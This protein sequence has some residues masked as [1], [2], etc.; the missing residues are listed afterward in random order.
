[1][2]RPMR[3]KTLELIYFN[4]G[5]G[6][7]A[8]ATAIETIAVQQGRPW[9]VRCVNLLEVLDPQGR[10]EKLTCMAP[11]ALY[12]KRLAK[13]W[14]FGLAQELKLLQGMIRLGH[15][16]MV[17]K[18][19][20]HWLRGEPDMVVSLVPNF[21]RAMQVSLAAALPGVP[22]VT[23]LT[24]MADHPPNFWIEP[25][26]PQH[27]VCGTARAMAQ[28]REQGCAESHLHRTSGMILRP[29]FYEP[30]MLDRRL[31]QVQLGLDPDRPTG[32]VMFGGHGSMAM[33]SI[34][35][36]LSDVQLILMCGHNAPL[37]SKLRAMK[38]AAT[39]VA[40]G[41]TPEVKRYMQLA[42]FFIGKPGPASLSE[43]V[44][45]GLPVVT[46]RNAWTMPQERYNTEWV[47]D[48]RLGLVA[49]SMSKLRPSVIELLSR[50]DEFKH[51]VRQVENRAIFEV[52]EI[53]AGILAAH[54]TPVPWQPGALGSGGAALTPNSQD[55]LQ[56]PN[57][58]LA[59]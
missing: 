10:F 14:T 4:A 49:R 17:K 50:L 25:D 20:Q 55:H 28:A 22:Y 36:Q 13:G 15:A 33:R 18:L 56:T 41:F 54:D 40:I 47:Q 43:A 5:G 29:D 24:D 30:L 9:R 37:A 16:A 21:N 51:S 39:H 58:V 53:L 12:N 44:Q 7:R 45:Q 35:E 11:E 59:Q 57:R 6:H 23:V 42:D 48:N 31:E 34:A 19:E 3:E 8:A 2:L 1:M 52:P 27:L 46:V 38:S 26:L 32:M